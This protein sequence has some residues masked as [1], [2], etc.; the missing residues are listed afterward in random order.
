[1]Q[2]HSIHRF[3]DKL[4]QDKVFAYTKRNIEA[5]KNEGHGSIGSLFS[6]ENGRLCSPVSINIDLTLACNYR[7]PHCI[8]K[9]IINTSKQIPFE[10]IVSTLTTLRLA[11]LRTVIIIG[12]GEP[13]LHTRFSDVVKTAKLLGLRIAIVTN[14]SNH[15]KILAVAGY[16]KK[17]DWVRLSLDSGTEETFNA[18]HKPLKKTTLESACQGASL[19]KKAN[20]EVQLGFS[21]VVITPETIEFD[22]SLTVNYKE[23]E[24]AASIAKK[25][26]FDY[27][28]FKPYLVRDKEGKETIP[29]FTDKKSRE[30]STVDVLKKCFKAA[31]RHKGKSFQVIASVNLLNMLDKDKLNLQPRMCRMQAFRQIVTPLGIYGCPAYRGDDVNII[32]NKDGYTS[33]GKLIK[34]SKKTA[35]MI[36]NFDASKEC[37]HIECI[38]N[39]TNWWLEAMD[40]GTAK[41]KEAAPIAYTQ[42]IFL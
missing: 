10:N 4:R 3:A 34:T 15:E 8:D 39:S 26:G 32:E 36:R 17:G 5:V 38:Y 29:Y 33:V 24:A 6:S 31:E 27:I 14:G 25:H 42:D 7:C 18:L 40:K 37:R 9:R 35:A 21:F 30:V 13:T 16:L 20:P 19:I 41:G 1:V 2:R 28:S 23:L 11:G 22:S 12:G